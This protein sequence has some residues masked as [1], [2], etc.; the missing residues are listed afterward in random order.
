MLQPVPADEFDE[1]WLWWRP[2]DARFRPTPHARLNALRRSVFD[3]ALA[4][5]KPG[6]R[7]KV[8]TY[9]FADRGVDVDAA[10]AL[11]KQHA[12]ERGWIVHRECFTDEPTGDLLP[13]RPQF[14][15][16]CRHAGGG[17]VDGVLAIDRGAM[18]STDEAYEA[19]LRWLHRHRA[20]IAVL[21][22]TV[23]GT[24]WTD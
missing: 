5:I 14:N 19:Y 16:A 3:D 1:S 22:P 9:V 11:L 17:F 12:R 8:S 13:V 7:I 20:F 2:R 24:Q 6:R 23:G 18:P 10:H 21:Q 4:A 15:L